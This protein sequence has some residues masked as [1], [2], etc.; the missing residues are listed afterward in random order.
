MQSDPPRLLIIGVGHFGEQHLKEWQKLVIEGRVSV[1]GLVVATEESRIRLKKFVDIPIHVGFDVGL[2]DGVDAVDIVTPASSHYG[3]ASAC[4]PYVDVL[5]EKPLCT[6]TEQAEDLYQI[7]SRHGRVLMAGHLYRFHPLR[8]VLNAAVRGRTQPP[9]LIT[10][11]FTNPV[12]QQRFGQELFLEWI[13]VFDLHYDIDA[14]D[15]RACRAWS[16]EYEAEASI[17]TQIGTNAVLRCGWSGLERV[18]KMTISYP[19]CHLHADFLD[20]ILATSRRNQTIKHIIGPEPRALQ[21]QLQHFLRTISQRRGLIPESQQVLETLRRAC[22]AADTARYPLRHSRSTNRPTAAI[23]GGGVFGASCALELSKIC[24]VTLFERHHKLLSEASY[25]NQWRHHSGF[26][27]PRSIETIQEVQAAKQEFESEFG[28]TIFRDIDAFYA[29]SAIGSEIS[30]E[31]YLDTCDANG[32]NYK[33]VDPPTQI[34]YA[35]KLSVCLHTD[36][37]VI[38]V[39]KLTELL[40]KRVSSSSNIELRLGSD[41]EAARF[42]ADGR[43]ELSFR[44]E[45]T[46]LQHECDFLVNATY[47]NSNLISRWLGFPL[48][49]LR[50]DQLELAVYRIPGAPRFMMTILDAPFTSLTSLG[51]GDLFMLSH[52]FQSLLASEVSVDGLPP[53]WSEPTLNYKNLLRHGLRYLPILENAEYVESRVGVRTVAAYSEDFDGRPTVV[54][55]HGF[56]CWSVLGG[57]LVTA[58]T[59][60]RE[61][62]DAIARES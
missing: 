52:R 30:R 53:N 36:E 31:R 49:Q 58:V 42:L 54:T 32:L 48:R 8:D 33:I 34:A 50:F 45:N 47:A 28:E 56:G 4:L 23:V 3:I 16:N 11:C 24:D 20:G 10:V 57:K 7:A 29:V 51:Y 35:E 27:Y 18:R 39:G 43:K 55:P 41:V 1:V 61:I 17:A 14:S 26:H 2:L 60:A 21:F 13:H 44:Q 59:N 12:S 22:R 5:V 6:T 40:M 38:D 62:V 25:L 19:D 37:S 46:T 9:E 15:I